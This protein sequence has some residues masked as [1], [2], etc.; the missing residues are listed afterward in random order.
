ME[1]AEARLQQYREQNDALSLEDRQNI[2]VQKLSD[3]NAAVTRAKT[4]RLQKEAMYRQLLEVQSDQAALDTFPAILAN[5]F[6][7]QQKTELA[8]L[9]RRQAQL[10]E[11]YGDK[12]PAMI[13]AQTAIQSAQMKLETE[14]AKVVQDCPTGALGFTR[15]DGGPETYAARNRCML[16]GSGFR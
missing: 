13:E 5:V 15:L 16:V 11:K 9:Q 7:Q 14:I 12:H 1:G 3:L 10:A 4:E 2:V 8:T 6:I